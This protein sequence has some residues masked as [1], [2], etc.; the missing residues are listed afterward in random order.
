M[1]HCDQSWVRK[2]R[3]YRGAFRQLPGS[4]VTN[5]VTL[6]VARWQNSPMKDEI[7][8]IQRRLT[9]ENMGAKLFAFFPGAF[10]RKRSSC[11]W[12]ACRQAVETVLVFL[13][14]RMTCYAK[15]DHSSFCGLYWDGTW[16]LDRFHGLR[17]YWKLATRMKGSLLIFII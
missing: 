9:G 15:D 1:Q 16:Y 14:N 17:Y 4:R 5:T 8:K 10:W 3:Q 11:H 13:D 7:P 2:Q 6:A 12:T